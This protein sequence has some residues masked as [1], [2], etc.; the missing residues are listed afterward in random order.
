MQDN[1]CSYYERFIWSM[2]NF[3]AV[4]M[5]DSLLFQ[6]AKLSQV[7][8]TLLITTLNIHFELLLNF[9]PWTSTAIYTGAHYGQR[10]LLVQL[11]GMCYV[12]VDAIDGAFSS[13]RYMNL[14]VM[15]SEQLCP[16][17]LWGFSTCDDDLNVCVVYGVE[18][19]LIE[20]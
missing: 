16:K 10:T 1:A 18:G 9:I 11:P 6:P 15:L 8:I 12:E 19:S 20:K 13:C 2:K 7:N 4:T 5:K 17:T 14:Y 3:P